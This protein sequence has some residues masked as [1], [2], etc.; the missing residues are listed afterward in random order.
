MTDGLHNVR[1]AVLKQEVDP[2]EWCVCT[3][4]FPAKLG[5]P[6]LPCELPNEFFL[7]QSNESYTQ[8]GMKIWDFKEESNCIQRTICCPSMRSFSMTSK[9]F[10]SEV[11]VTA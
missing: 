7:F 1:Y 8:L 3:L 10:Y 2:L 11:P 4:P 5:I 9:D 6:C